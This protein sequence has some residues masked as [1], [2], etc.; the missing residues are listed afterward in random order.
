RRVVGGKL[1]L[2]VAGLPDTGAAQL[3]ALAVEER[4]GRDLEER[5]LPLA[6]LEG[7]AVQEAL[8]I[9]G[10]EIAQLD[11]VPPLNVNEHPLPLTQ[12]LDLRVDHLVV[13]RLVHARERKAE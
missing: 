9:D 12:L 2:D 5:V 7:L 11:G 8:V 3:L 10:G 13:D 1:H 4:P 6:A